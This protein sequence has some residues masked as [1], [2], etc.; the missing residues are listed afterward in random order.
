MLL[1]HLKSF[2]YQPLP[3]CN[4]WVNNVTTEPG[5]LLHQMLMLLFE[6]RFKNR[7]VTSKGLGLPFTHIV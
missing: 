6:E 4:N 7:I 1:T 5:Y 2:V 3:F